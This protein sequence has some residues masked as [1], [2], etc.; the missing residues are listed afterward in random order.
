[1]SEELK[2]CPF[3]GKEQSE[4]NFFSCDG[5]PQ[6]CGCWE[7]THSGEEAVNVWNTRPIEDELRAEIARRDEIITRL[8]E[9]INDNNNNFSV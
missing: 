7:T 5:Y 9:R 4:E 2:P 6:A 8:K 1:M 3:C